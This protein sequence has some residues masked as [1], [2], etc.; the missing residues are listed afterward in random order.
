MHI[1]F[2]NKFRREENKKYAKKPSY[3]FL[4]FINSNRNT[5]LLQ[6]KLAMSSINLAF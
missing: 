2:I 4:L 3:I 6:I 1:Y 5:I